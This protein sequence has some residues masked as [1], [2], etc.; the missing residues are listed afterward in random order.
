MIMWKRMEGLI[1]VIK[2]AV[3]F[4]ILVPFLDMLTFDRIYAAERRGQ[5]A[6]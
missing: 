5:Y 3:S 2:K 6:T 4:D 1:I